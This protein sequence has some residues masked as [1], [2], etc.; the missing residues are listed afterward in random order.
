L[1]YVRSRRKR[2]PLVIYLLARC[3][4]VNITVGVDYVGVA[5]DECTYF[6]CLV[7]IFCGERRSNFNL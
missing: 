2:L 6:R 5:M 1:A 4:I 3:H 7:M